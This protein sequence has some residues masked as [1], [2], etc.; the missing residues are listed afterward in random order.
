MLSE[1]DVWQD[2]ANEDGS[3]LEEVVLEILNSYLGSSSGYRIEKKPRH[4]AKAYAGQWGAVPDLSV[5]NIRNKRIVW[6]EIKRQN[7]K[8]NAHER[9]CKY[10]TPGMLAKGRELGGVARP[11]FFVFSG[12]MVTAPKYSAELDTWFDSDGWRDHLLKWR[13]HDPVELC[14]WFDDAI[15]PSLD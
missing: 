7:A 13:Q 4:L 15:R 2:R 5:E 11:Y 14:E 1:R 6:I 8:G 3:R 9:A 12:P 10:F